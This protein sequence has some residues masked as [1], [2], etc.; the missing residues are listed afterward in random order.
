MT[1]LLK[2]YLYAKSNF[3]EFVSAFPNQLNLVE[4]V[5]YEFYFQVFDNDAIHN[6]QKHKEHGL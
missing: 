2:K 1:S 5:D 3:D 6:Y 4:G